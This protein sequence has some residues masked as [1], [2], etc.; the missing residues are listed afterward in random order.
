MRKKTLFLLNYTRYMKQWNKVLYSPS[1]ISW[2]VAKPI[3]D[4]GSPSGN[5]YNLLFVSVIIHPNHPSDKVQRLF[6]HTELEHTPSNLYQEASRGIS[7][8]IG[9]AGG[10]PGVCW[11]NLWKVVGC[12]GIDHFRLGHPTTSEAQCRICNHWKWSRACQDRE[13]FRLLGGFWRF[14]F[15]GFGWGMVGSK[16]DIHTWK[17]KHLHPG[18]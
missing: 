4:P 13:R 12:V 8:I 6:Q 7:F 9:V 2:N 5:L 11:N 18:R 1:K 14:F 3:R 10:L 17:S 16:Q 15:G